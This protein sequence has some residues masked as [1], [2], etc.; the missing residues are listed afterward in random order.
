MTRRVLIG[1][2]NGTMGMWVTPAGKDVVTST[3]PADFMVDT[4]RLNLRPVMAGV[5]GSPTPISLPYVSGTAPSFNGSTASAGYAVYYKDY[6]HNLGYVPVCFFCIGSSVAGEIYPTIKVLSDR[7]RL[8]H[9]RYRPVDNTR[10]FPN[11]YSDY[12][13]FNQ[14]WTW[15]DHPWRPLC[16]A[17]SSIDYTCTINYVIYGKSTGLS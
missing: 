6:M 17:P 13:P 7:I 16:G 8:Y 1:N 4:T 12:N 2:K 14:T 9:R 10:T 5:L 3:S 11:W 15:N